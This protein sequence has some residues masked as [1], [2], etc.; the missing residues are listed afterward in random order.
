M[1]AP[2][3]IP[4]FYAVAMGVDALAAL[5]FGRLFDRFG[6]SVLVASTLLSAAFAPLA[7]LGG[8]SVALLGV[9]PK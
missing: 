2:D 8:P 7:F 9:S 3:W 5:V 1:V 6:L 4:V